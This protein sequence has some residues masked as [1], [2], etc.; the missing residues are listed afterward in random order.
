MEALKVDSPAETAVSLRVLIYTNR[1]F[2][3]EMIVGRLRGTGFEPDWHQADSETSYIARLDD[4]PEIVFVDDN[5]PDIDPMRALA[6]IQQR[7]IDTPVIVI[8]GTAD[9]ESAAV[10]Y[11]ERG[12]ADYLVRDRPA[13]LGQAVAQAL[14][15]R[16]LRDQKQQ[17]EKSLQESGDL[18]RT[19]VENASDAIAIYAGTERV[20]VNAAFLKLFGVEDEVKSIGV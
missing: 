9:D 5:P 16:T 17:A 14:E 19:L 11:M 13:R 2:D 1:S 4:F 10:E 7:G 3:A 18:Y 12:A 6:L 8:A 15:R 20:Y